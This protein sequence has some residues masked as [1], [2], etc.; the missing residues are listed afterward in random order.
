MGCEAD[1]RYA[2]G[3]K[4]LFSV[5]PAGAS[6]AALLLLRI[7]AA[8]LL[9]VLWH[10][11]GFSAWSYLPAA[12]LGIALIVGFFTRL[13]ALAVAA[14]ALLA[15]MRLEGLSA[16]LLAL[17]GTSAVALALLGAGAY[18]IDARLFGRRIIDFGP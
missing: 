18:S 4:R 9:G 3:V 1:L 17:Q 6:G 16:L 5:F 2:M 15:L 10:L 13:A 7:S 12:I 14:L 11:S 8:L